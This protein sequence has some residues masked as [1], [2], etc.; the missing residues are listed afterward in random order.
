MVD[1]L[2]ARFSLSPLP[3]EVDACW[4]MQV[5]ST[6]AR[7]KRL[8]WILDAGPGRLAG[9][10]SHDGANN[11]AADFLQYQNI[12]SWSRC[13]Y[14]L[15]NQKVYGLSRILQMIFG[16]KIF[17]L[18]FFSLSSPLWIK[19]FRWKLMSI[20]VDLGELQS[21]AVLFHFCQFLLRV[22]NLRFL[23][24]SAHP[25]YRKPFSFLFIFIVAIHIFL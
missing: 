13:V 8:M 25:K 4:L 7:E 5:A 11:F 24:V 22:G 18:L 19:S 12:S 2:S 16:L 14:S 1:T 15:F 21:S 9:A 20:S 17:G 6:L 23:F 10:E 3:P